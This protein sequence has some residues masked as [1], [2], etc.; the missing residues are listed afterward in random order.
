MAKQP[1]REDQG[2]CNQCLLARAERGFLAQLLGSDL[3]SCRDQRCTE[4]ESPP[5]SRAAQAPPRSTRPR[6]SAGD[7]HGAAPA[8]SRATC[9]SRQV[10]PERLAAEPP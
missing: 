7:Q 9:A 3:P 2:V 8:V 4:D 6:S 5:S 10:W 1:S